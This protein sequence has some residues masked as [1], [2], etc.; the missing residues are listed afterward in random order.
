M[1]S[2][3]SREDLSDVVA[4][5]PHGR[6]WRVLKPREFEIRV[7]PTYFEH[8]KFSSFIRQANGWGFRRITQGKDRNSYYHE[9]FLRGLPHLCKMM[10]RPGVSEKQAADA[11]Q[12]PDFY[13]IAEESPVP[14]K[15]EDA[16]IL[17]ECTLQGGPKARMPIFFGTLNS[18]TSSSANTVASAEG[19]MP[20][21]VSAS[22]HLHFG[23]ESS[24]VRQAQ[25]AR[26]TTHDFQQSP[27]NHP[28]V[29]QP[30]DTNSKG[31]LPMDMNLAPQA[32]A[33]PCATHP[34]TSGANHV[35]QQQYCSL[36]PASVTFLPTT[37]SRHT[38]PS[39]FSHHPPQQFD[40]ASGL[41]THSFVASNGG[42]SGQIDTSD[43]AAQFAAGFAAATALSQQQLRAFLGQ[44]LASVQN[45]Q[46]QNL[47]NN[48]SSVTAAVPVAHLQAPHPHGYLQNVQ[49]RQTHHHQQRPCTLPASRHQPQQ[50][51][52]PHHSDPQNHQCRDSHNH[53]S[54]TQSATGYTSRQP[55]N[56]AAHH[57]DCQTSVEVW[58]P[59]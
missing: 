59:S 40:Q 21:T 57:D 3:L 2:I 32:I 16:S 48:F 27:R 14:E 23:I 42:S 22:Q 1:H 54:Q 20:C 10:K 47:L 15:A 41:G 17:L 25:F 43:P 35:P 13:K 49:G 18:N 29:T 4:W 7:I 51:P 46:T 9:M 11:D 58:T 56:N 33:V 24:H 52:P 37:I 30:T 55:P 8:S 50:Q 28:R 5:M 26:S 6:S 45:T 39:D 12:E 31:F 38:N 19:S 44:A 36:T 53:H 34:I